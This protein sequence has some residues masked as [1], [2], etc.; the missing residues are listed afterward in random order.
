MNKMKIFL[1]AIAGMLSAGAYAQ[2]ALPQP[3]PRAKVSQTLGVT[4]ITVDYSRPAV[5]GRKVW[6]DLVPFGKVWRTGANSAT[7]ITLSTNAEIGGREISKGEYAL[8]TIPGEKEWTII[9]NTNEGQ[10]GSVNH[11]SELDVVRLNAVPKKSAEFKERFEVRINPTSDNEAF[12]VLGWENLEVQ[13]PVR[14]NSVENAGKNIAEYAQK[15]GSLWY[16]LAKATIYSHENNINKDQQL[17]WI[18]QSIALEDHFYNKM[19]KA[20][21]LHAS[22]NKAE[23]YSWMAQAKDFGEKNPSGFYDAYKN[24][25]EKSLAD[26][27][28]FAPKKKKK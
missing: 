18:D 21:V 13:F 20:K 8:F 5:K 12:I 22:G 14:V 23:A 10:K 6:G 2:L 7:T 27:S 15:S 11:K 19:I 9:I 24:E 28:A 4:E 1:F 25:I 17:K 26:W 3:S 16:D